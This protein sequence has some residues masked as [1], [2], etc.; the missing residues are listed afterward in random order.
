MVSKLLAEV[1]LQIAHV[2]VK[3]VRE[4]EDL[5]KVIKGEERLVKAMKRRQLES[6]NVK[7]YLT[8]TASA[9]VV[10]KGNSTKCFVCTARVTNFS[11]M[12]V[13]SRCQSPVKGFKKG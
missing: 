7:R 9:L 13:M 5:M 8:S 2:S 4:V 1:Y 6:T 11:S 12:R 10:R 3:E